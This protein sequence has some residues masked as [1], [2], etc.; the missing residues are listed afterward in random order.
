MMLAAA[1]SRCQLLRSADI[2]AIFFIFHFISLAGFSFERCCHYCLLRR[3]FR[4]CLALFHRQRHDMFYGFDA[5]DFRLR[6]TRRLSL[7]LIFRRRFH[8]FI[9]IFSRFRRFA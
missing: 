5:A 1:A 4:M 7:G 8:C 2:A 9:S 6:L 3:D